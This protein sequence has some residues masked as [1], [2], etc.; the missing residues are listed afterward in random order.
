[1]ASAVRLRLK[2]HGRDRRL[3]A[4]RGS[5]GRCAQPDLL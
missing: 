2:A 4:L 3:K 1:M 5:N